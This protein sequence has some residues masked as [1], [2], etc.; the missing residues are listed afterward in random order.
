MNEISKNKEKK[1][2]SQTS[3]IIEKNKGKNNSLDKEYKEKIKDKNRQNKIFN[4]YKLNQKLNM[5]KIRLR[6]DKSTKELK[7][8]EKA[9]YPLKLKKINKNNNIE[10]NRSKFNFLLNA[11]IIFLLISITNEISSIRKLNYYSSLFITFSKSGNMVFLNKNYLYE[12][13]Y[14]WIDNVQRS[15]GQSSEEKYNILLNEGEATIRVGWNNPVDSTSYMFSGLNNIIKIDLS[16]FDS[17]MVTDM[18][19]MFD[20]CSSLLSL[21][22]RNLI[23][24]SVVNLN[25]M[26]HSCKSLQEVDLSNK[27]FSSAK[28]MAGMFSECNTHLLESLDLSNFK[29]KSLL[30][31]KKMFN[32]C[33][34]L[35]YLDISSFDTSLV[36]DM[37][38]LFHSCNVLESIDISNFITTKFIPTNGLFQDCTKLKS[39]KFPSKNK[40]LSSNMQYMFEGCS[41]LTSLDLSYFDTSSVTTMEYMFTDCSELN[42]VN[43]SLIDTSSVRTMGFMFKNCQ[44]LERIDLSMISTLSLTSMNNMFYNCKSLLFLNLKNLEINR[45]DI[46]DM[47]NEVTKGDLILCYDENLANN[48]ITNYGY[49]FKDCNN[50]CFRHSTKLISELKTCVDDCYKD[51]DTYKLEFNEKCYENCPEDTILSNN[52]CRT[53]IKCEYFSNLDESECFESMPEGYYIVDNENKIIEKC[54]KNCKTCDKK[55]DDDINNCKTCKDEYF[56]EN[57]NCVKQCTYNVYINNDNIKVCSCP[58]NIKC[59]ECS[60]E[61]LQSNLCIT[62][63]DH[64]NYFPKFSEKNNIFINCYQS[65]KEH[66]LINGYFFPCYES[67]DECSDVGS[68][69]QH[70]CTEC[71]SGYKFLNEKDKSE[72]CYP[73]CDH[74]YF[75]D[76]SNKFQCTLSDQCPV[77]KSKFVE[78]K[79]NVSLIVKMM[80]LLN[81]NI[82]VNAIGNV[83]IKKIK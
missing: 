72:N 25:S 29:T 42:Y 80:I 3:N 68:E 34:N 36:N 13:D 50:D 9:L 54:Y 31:M 21:D 7:Y 28:T 59:K 6:K 11:I 69:N 2:I 73:I 41:S 22:L 77:H 40:L 74:F 16:Q 57:G 39:I 56:Y 67:C 24:S 33:Q 4:L 19:Y 17:S 5:R 18:S 66:Y 10:S 49:L 65:L 37:S 61:S 71:K 78:E 70:L 53:N 38:D 76:E 30:S 47:L 51:G 32:S 43:L 82:M 48:L 1:K 46:G 58:L 14:V 52:I 63:N 35:K 27:D 8:T 81:M 83:Q 26:F 60:D 79:K 12:P 55:G 20:G 62:C 23:M 44:K 75:F 15:F 45:F 64:D